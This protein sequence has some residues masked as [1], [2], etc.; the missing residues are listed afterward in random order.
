MP[1]VVKG[2]VKLPLDA[3]GP[4]DVVAADIAGWVSVAVRL[5]LRREDVRT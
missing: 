1:G 3:L 2:I 5:E 4:E